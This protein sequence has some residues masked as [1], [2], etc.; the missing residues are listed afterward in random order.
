MI[1][2]ETIRA[3]EDKALAL[4][5]LIVRD[6]IGEGKVGHLGGSCSLAEIV[7]TLYFHKHTS[8]P[9]LATREQH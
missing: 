8:H 5:E 9:F 3:I 4:R 1:A 2:A 6:L 7:A